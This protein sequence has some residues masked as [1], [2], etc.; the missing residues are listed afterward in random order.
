M[1][2]HRSICLPRTIIFVTLPTILVSR[3]KKETVKNGIS[4]I[5]LRKEGILTLLLHSL[6]SGVEDP[7][8]TG[9]LPP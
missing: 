5:D 9:D 3:E 1:V 7:Q 2:H 8:R 6:I 4:F